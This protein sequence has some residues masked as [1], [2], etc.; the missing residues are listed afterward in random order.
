MMYGAVAGMFESKKHSNP[1]ECAK[2]EL[3][4]EAQLKTENWIPLLKDEN[5]NVPFEKYSDNRFHPYLAIDC[6]SVENPRPMDDEEYIVV[7][8][9]VTYDQLME[10]ISTGKL[11]VI[12]SYTA[13]MGIRKLTEMGIPLRKEL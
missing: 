13:L 8:R 4:E 1:L 5:T 3:E 6:E 9:G 11:N 2:C 12:S 7:K 10:L